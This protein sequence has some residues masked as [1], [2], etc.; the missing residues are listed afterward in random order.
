MSDNSK[1]KN[2]PDNASQ[3]TSVHAPTSEDFTGGAVERAV[4]KESLQHPATIY[5]LAGSALALSWSVIVTPTPASLGLMLGLAFASAS[6]FVYNYVVKGPERAK[7]YV[8]RLRELRR[9]S[10][11]GSL[12]QL[13]A[14]FDR[15]GF[16]EAAKEAQELKT[17]YEQLNEYLKQSNQLPSVDRFSVLAEES[18]RQGISTLQQALAIFTAMESVDLESLQRDLVRW[19]R[20]LSA[21]DQQSSEFKTLKQQI[22]AHS[23]RINLCEQSDEKLS[24]L[25]AESNEIETALQTTYLELVDS[26]NQ[27]LDDFLRQDGGAVNRLNQAVEAARRVEQRLRGDDAEEQ[28]KQKKYID[29]DVPKETQQN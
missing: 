10:E 25:I 16:G 24:Q 18:L 2:E 21:L 3:K 14:T 6:S 17:A 7:D 26:G 29:L 12:D 23:K 27:N 15:I 13:T 9:R 5:P 4:L 11:V 1:V 28:A 20:R 22:D 19:Q 8:N